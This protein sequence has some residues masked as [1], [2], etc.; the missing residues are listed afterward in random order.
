MLAHIELDR[1]FLPL[2]D[3]DEYDPDTLRA[4]AAAG[5]D[6]IHWPELLAMKRVVILAEAGTG[7]THEL[8][9]TTRRLRRQKKAAAFFCR[10]E[11][12]ADR[13][14]EDALAEGSDTEFRSWLEGDN[15]AWFFLDSVDEARL[16]HSRSFERALRVMARRLDHA[17]SRAHIFITARVTDWRATADLALVTEI[18]PPVTA[19]NKVAPLQAEGAPV[20]PGG[21]RAV[22]PAEKAAQDTV[23]IVQLAPL[24]IDQMRRFAAGQKVHDVAAFMDAIERTD[25]KIFAERPQDLLDLVA[26]GMSMA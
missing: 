20:E 15:A 6:R 14:L 5:S 17:V 18:L 24:T 19:R 3:G 23:R 11:E 22:R 4:K 12:L 10:I 21:D 2:G 26:Y 25:A 1:T 16:A 9:E 7:K 13:S 8:R